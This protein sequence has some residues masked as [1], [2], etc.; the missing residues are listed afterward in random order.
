[1]TWRPGWPGDYVSAIVYEYLQKQHQR[2]NGEVLCPDPSWPES[3][4]TSLHEVETGEGKACL[5]CK[6]V[7]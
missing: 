6:A 1:M 4:R 5:G 2:R 7:V 3:M